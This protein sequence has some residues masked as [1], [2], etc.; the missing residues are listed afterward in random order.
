MSVQQLFP[1]PVYNNADAVAPADAEAIRAFILYHY[2]QYG[3]DQADENL[4]DSRIAREL[5]P[6]MEIA[7]RAMHAAF[8]ALLEVSGRHDLDLRLTT[9]KYNVMTAGEH[10]P[11]HMHRG[12]DAFAIL[13]LDNLFM[14]DGGQLVLH[15]PTFT[16]SVFTPT[17]TMLIPPT[18]GSII[19]APA[20]L[21]HSVNPYY[22]NKPRVCLVVNAVV[23]VP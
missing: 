19:A 21:W 13:Y 10:R 16:D 7:K 12:I 23:D 2:R 14:R 17:N 5:C 15:N 6:Q 3:S 4:F 8:G 22:G 9:S 20:Y 1:T 11:I 18:I